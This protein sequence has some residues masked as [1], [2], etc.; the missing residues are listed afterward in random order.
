MKFELKKTENNIVISTN[1]KVV[2]DNKS[3]YYII[4]MESFF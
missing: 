3:L 2:N 1:F 4:Y